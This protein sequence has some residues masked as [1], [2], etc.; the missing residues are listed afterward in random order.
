MAER[1]ER[2]EL[3][4]EAYADAML[5]LRENHEE[6]FDR[7]LKHEQEVRNIK[8]SDKGGSETEEDGTRRERPQSSLTSWSDVLG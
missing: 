3:M 8:P 1:T 6:E 4:D 2:Q 5:K 7:L